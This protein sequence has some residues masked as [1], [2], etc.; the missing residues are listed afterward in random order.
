MNILLDTNIILDIALKRP[1][2]FKPAIQL[3]Q[4]AQQEHIGI[5]ITA[6]TITDLYY[7]TRKAK[8][9]TIAINFIN[10]LLQ[11]TEV[12]GVDKSIIRRALQSNIT[13]FEDAIQECAAN[14]YHIPI[15]ITRNEADFKNSTLQIYSAEA[16]LDYYSQLS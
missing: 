1:A 13:D 10:H 2:F 7:I 16:F 6:T 8:N 4:T 3:L 14:A 15:I 11:I 12:A 5:F 9:H